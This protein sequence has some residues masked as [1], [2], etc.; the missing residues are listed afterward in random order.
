VSEAPVDRHDEGAEQAPAP[1]LFEHV[2]REP[3]LSDKVAN[4]MLETI[5]SRRLEVGDRLPSERELGEQF[6]V[7]RTVVREAVRALVAKGV[8]EVRSGSGLRVAAVD[9]ESVRESMSLFLRGGEIDFEK[10]HEVRSLLEGHLAGL[11]AERATDLDIAELR[12]IH[13]RMVREA[14]DL[15]AASRDDLAFHRRVALSTHN[16]LFLVLMDSIGGSLLDIRR[17]N[18][19]S[20]SM[21]MTLSQHEAI[22]AAIEA[23]RPDPARAAMIDHLEAVAS[24]WREHMAPAPRA[25]TE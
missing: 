5:L 3:R 14:G 7:S 18:L 13:E 1:A 19:G 20:G 2:E 25:A 16:E 4:M 22:L 24:W 23:R 21:P 10:V 17:A 11:A 6:G 12:S 8:I 15:E 9:A